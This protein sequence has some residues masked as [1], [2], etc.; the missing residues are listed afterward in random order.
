MTLLITCDLGGTSCVEKV[1]KP[2][3]NPNGWITLQGKQRIDLCA[4]C[5][6]HVKRQIKDQS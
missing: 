6:A 3:G 1:V 2:R 4:P 5:A